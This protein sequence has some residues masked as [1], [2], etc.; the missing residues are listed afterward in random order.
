[1]IDGMHIKLCFPFLRR[2]VMKQLLAALITTLLL[3]SH[4]HA[5]EG[6]AKPQ[7]EPTAAQKAQREKMKTCN[8]EAKAKELKGDERKAFMQGC[9]SKSGD[10]TAGKSDKANKV[11]S[12]EKAEQCKQEAT[13]QKLKGDER[14]AYLATCLEA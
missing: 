2:I 7:K 8:Q 6:E 3:V 11:A 10:T 9:L 12:K 5:A 13:E 14:K 1:M 4:S